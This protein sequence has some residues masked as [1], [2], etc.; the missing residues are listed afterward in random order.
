MTTKPQAAGYI[1]QDKQGIAIHGF[2]E[3]VGEAW[4]MVVDGAGP[5]FDAHGNEKA[6][7]QAY[8]EDFKTYG[9]TAALIEQVRTEGG[10]IAWGLVAGVACTT[11]EEE[12][13]Q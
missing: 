9:A 10:A 3:T 13:A 6:D 4:A 1:I 2:G 8:T 12:G 5:F 11:D 7:E